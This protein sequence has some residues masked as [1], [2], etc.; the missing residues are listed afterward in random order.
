MSDTSTQRWRRVEPPR[1]LNGWE[2]QVL[3]SILSAP[4]ESHEGLKAQVEVTRVYEESPT[5]P[6]VMLHVDRGAQT[7]TA[8]DGRPWSGIVPFELISRTADGV[9]MWA[10][11]DTRDGCLYYLEVQRAD[12]VP[13]QELPDLAEMELRPL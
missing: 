7:A 9:P 13:L 5:D 6:S 12:G 3:S 8:K 11:L 1:P 2:R 4:F 10:L